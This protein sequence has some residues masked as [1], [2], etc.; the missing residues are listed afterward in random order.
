MKQY[1]EEQII[2]SHLLKNK[3]I[4]KFSE[5]QLTEIHKIKNSLSAWSKKNRLI[6]N[7][8]EAIPFI[9]L[10]LQWLF[11]ICLSPHHIQNKTILFITIGILHGFIGYQW[12]VYSIPE[13]AGHGLF[14]NGQNKLRKIL[15]ILSFNSSRLM[16]ADPINYKNHITSRIPRF[17]KRWNSGKL[18]IKK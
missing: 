7:A 9:A 17:R 11:I 3:E 1:Q 18:R 16:M 2:L 5:F 13:G 8:I 14:R 12:V 6:H 15:Q 10:I 4:P